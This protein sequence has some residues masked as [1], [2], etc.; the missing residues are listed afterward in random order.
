MKT[1]NI[2]LATVFALIS[3]CSNAQTQQAVKKETVKVWGNCEMCQSRIEKA[4]K[5][6]GATFAKWNVDNKIL[7]VSYS[8]SK[9][10]INTIEKSVAAAGYDTEHLK[11]SDDGYSKLPECC[12]YYRKTVVAGETSSKSE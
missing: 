4:A 7:T 10:T 2:F 8:P 11:G 9:A 1:I 12:Q 6:A 5:A 3:I